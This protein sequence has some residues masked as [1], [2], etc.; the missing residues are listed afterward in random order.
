MN[1]FMQKRAF[2]SLTMVAIFLII[3]VY[4]Q[5]AKIQSISLNNSTMYAKSNLLNE[6][7]VAH[8]PRD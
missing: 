3:G 8:G 7:R 2:S 4:A 1:T 5:T 6:A